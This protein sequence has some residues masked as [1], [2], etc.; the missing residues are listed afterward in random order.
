MRILIAPDKF[1]DAL[2]AAEVALALKTGIEEALG[3]VHINLLPLADGGEG[4]A[5]LLTRINN[6]LMRKAIVKGP[7][8]E[9]TDAYWGYSA[10]EKQVFLELAEASGLRLIPE[11]LRNPLKTS[12]YGTGELIK[13]A[14][15]AGG[16]NFVIGLGGSATNDGGTGMAAA[17]GYRF[18][19]GQ[20]RLIPYPC[21]KD[22]IR[23]RHIDES[24]RHPL[25]KNAS[26]KAACDVENP[27][28]GPDGATY[29]FGPQKGADAQMLAQLEEGMQNLAA[30]LKSELGKEVASIPGSSAAG[31]AGAGVLAFLTGRLCSGAELILAYSQFDQHLQQADLL[32]SGEGKLDAS[33]LQGKL[34]GALLKK[35][36]EKKVPLIIFCGSSEVPPEILKEAGLQEVI[37]VSVHENQL[38]LALQNSAK[39]L[40]MAAKQ[41]FQ[42]H[43]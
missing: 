18:Y 36:R 25:L 17:L 13:T 4:T 20:G 12:T 26:F 19:D 10:Q 33:S 2:T 31:G 24:Q 15:K 40:Q 30:L 42:N 27:L 34:I 43:F 11:T 35:A 23:I 39:N 6:G 29:T 28:L 7:L 32:I 3:N 16:E 5:A 1:K 41:Y 14:L 9:K 38:A 37:P 21:G 8:L 22:L